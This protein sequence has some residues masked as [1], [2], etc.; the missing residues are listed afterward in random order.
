MSIDVKNHLDKLTSENVIKF[1]EDR[2]LPT[3]DQLSLKFLQSYYENQI[4]PYTFVYKCPNSMS[5]EFSVE[6][7]NFCHLILGTIPKGISKASQYK[8]LAGYEAINNNIVTLNNLPAQ[9]KEFIKNVRKKARG[10]IYL[11]TLLDYPTPTIIYNKE[12]VESGKI[13]VG[14][15]NIDADFLLCKKIGNQ[16]LHLFLKNRNVKKDNPITVPISFLIQPV[17]KSRYLNNQ[18]PLIVLGKHKFKR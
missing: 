15:S 17:S 9:P 2:V 1:K 5:I 11:D 4:L 6:K 10:F 14:E 3:I 12:I 8:G 16:N 7:E 13:P 18:K